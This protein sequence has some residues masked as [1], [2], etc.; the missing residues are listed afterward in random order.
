MLKKMYL[1]IIPCCLVVAKADACSPRGQVNFY[2]DTSKHLYIKVKRVR[3]SDMICFTTQERQRSKTEKEKCSKEFLFS[4]QD[5]TVLPKDK[6][7]DVCSVDRNQF[8]IVGFNVTYKHDGIMHAGPKGEVVEYEEASD[9]SSVFITM[10]RGG[11][12]RRIAS[13]GC[14]PRF[15]ETCNITFLYQYPPPST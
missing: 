8:A 7:M 3:I 6:V 4:Y 14:F 13:T 5:I 10:L 9:S 11:N 12:T 2:N 1:F 15:S